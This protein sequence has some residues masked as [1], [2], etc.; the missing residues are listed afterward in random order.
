MN[1]AGRYESIHGDISPVS[2][3]IFRLVGFCWGRTGHIPLLKTSRPAASQRI[4]VKINL[5]IWGIKKGMHPLVKVGI[6][7]QLSCAVPG[8][9]TQG[10]L[11]LQ[12]VPQARVCSYHIPL[13]LVA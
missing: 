9:L 4:P 13:T 5:S 10:V 12:G 1:P 8:Q 7:N 2:P 3:C 11:S 6:I